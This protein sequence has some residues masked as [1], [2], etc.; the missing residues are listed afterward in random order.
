MPLRILQRPYAQ[1]RMHAGADTTLPEQN[2]RSAARPHRHTDRDNAR[3]FQ[4]HIPVGPGRKQ[5]RHTP[6]GDKGKADT[7]ATLQGTPRNTLQRA[8]DRTHDP[9]IRRARRGRHQPAAHC[10]GAPQPVCQGLQPHTES[11]AHDSRP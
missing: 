10:N 6:T 8:D 7:G 5:R 4:R 11:G 3:A 9:P 2:Q 1:M